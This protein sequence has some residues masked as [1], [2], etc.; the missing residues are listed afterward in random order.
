MRCKRRRSPRL[1][2]GT[3]WSAP[4]WAEFCALI[5]VAR[6]RSGKPS[7]PFLN[8]RLYPLLGTN[9]FRDIISGSNGAYHAG[10]GYD[11]VTGLG[12]PDMKQLV[13]N[14]S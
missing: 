5:N 9:C 10:T 8:P 6:H 11:M 14:L 1:A 4:V 2:L 3:S 12:V 13:N 7:L